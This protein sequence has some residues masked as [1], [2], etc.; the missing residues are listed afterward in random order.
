MM[1]PR[2]DAKPLIWLHGEIRTPPFSPLS[3]IEAGMLLRQ[4][5]NGERLGMPQSRPMPRIGISCHE[6][7]LHSG[8][9]S[10]RIIYSIDPDAIVILEVFAK[11]SRATPLSVIEVC[12]KRLAMYRRISATGPEK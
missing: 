6:L 4:L 2:K 8:D 3:R 10:W 12:K 7:R 9:V 1:R 5:Q 11:R